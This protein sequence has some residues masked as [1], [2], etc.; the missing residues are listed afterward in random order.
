MTPKHPIMNTY[1]FVSTSDK[2]TP[3]DSSHF[4][5]IIRQQP[6]Q[7]RLCN[8]KERGNR[9]PIDPPP[10]IQLKVDEYGGFFV[11]GDI[12]I[13]VEGRYRLRFSLFE[14][15][16][17]EVI[18][19]QSIIS[20][21]FTIY[22]AK[23]FPGASES[24]FLSRSFSDQGVRI[25]IRKEHRGLS[26]RS[27]P[28]IIQPTEK[29]SLEPYYSSS[30]SSSHYTTSD[31]LIN[32]N[33]S[34]NYLQNTGYT[35]PNSWQKSRVF[36]S[37]NHDDSGFDDQMSVLSS[38]TFEFTS[39]ATSSHNESFFLNDRLKHPYYF[40]PSLPPPPES[41]TRS[42][43]LPPYLSSSQHQHH[44]KLDY[45]ITKT[46]IDDNNN[47][48]ATTAAVNNSRLS[49]IASQLPTPKTSTDV[50]GTRSNQLLLTPYS[51]NMATSIDSYRDDNII[52]L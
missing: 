43:T 24:T 2:Q 17:N 18:H 19:L 36:V 8:S 10:I 49:S 50:D 41:S 13:R 7:A 23:A 51:P 42:F 9:R 45:N 26:K 31:Y 47:N 39:S 40:R 3:L 16:K 52:S 15:I 22:S 37:N 35:S 44:T 21:I 48:T 32:N 38:S 20:D 12:S 14:V 30:S 1:N 34:P 46:D 4:R 33:N 25:R 11:F 29:L 27:K 28:E 6:K 5:L